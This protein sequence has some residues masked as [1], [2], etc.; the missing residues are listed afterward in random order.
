MSQEMEHIGQ[1]LQKKREEMHITL[2]EVE[3]S[4]SIRSGFIRAIEKGKIN[5][6]V[7]GVYA[8]G[9]IKQYAG[10]LG[11]DVEQMIRENPAAFKMRHENHEFAYGIGTLE[12]RG[13]LGGGAKWLPNLLWTGGVAAAIILA[14]YF[15]K[16][17][18][19][20]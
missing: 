2:K 6:F 5:E 10:F 4:I 18:G 15:A 12:T 16:A 7:S 3:N 13:S 9:F 14:Y 17:I 11:V 1:K 8:L 20:L 19:I